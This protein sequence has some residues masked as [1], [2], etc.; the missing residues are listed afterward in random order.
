MCEKLG[1]L[2]AQKTRQ[3]FIH[4][5][6]L[7]VCLQW[8]YHL[9]ICKCHYRQGWSLVYQIVSKPLPTDLSKLPKVY[10]NKYLTTQEKQPA[11]R[12]VPVK[13]QLIH[14]ILSN[15][16]R[17]VPGNHLLLSSLRIYVFTSWFTCRQLWNS[18]RPKTTEKCAKGSAA[19]SG[20]YSLNN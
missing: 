2:Y 19:K 17:N 13:R 3:Q 7:V 16:V 10:P 4:A 9:V 1:Q 20:F 15:L 11:L 5:T 12:G 14:Q 6:I 18:T 8:E